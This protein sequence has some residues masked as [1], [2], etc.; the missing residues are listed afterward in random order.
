[1][2]K[3]DVYDKLEEYKKRKAQL[4]QINKP[5]SLLATMI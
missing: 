3:A 4:E 5:K 2:T 1:M